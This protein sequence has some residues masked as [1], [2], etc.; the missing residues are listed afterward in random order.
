MASKM[1]T[2]HPGAEFIYRVGILKAVV[3]SSLPLAEVKRRMLSEPCGTKARWRYS[4]T[5][6]P[7]LDN[8]TTHKHY[9]FEC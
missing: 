3:C 7:C 9:L 8:P 2:T 1:K 5:I 6:S 4:E